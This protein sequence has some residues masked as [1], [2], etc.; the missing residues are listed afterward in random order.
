MSVSVCSICSNRSSN[1][2]I[3]AQEMMFG[4]RESYEYLECAECRCLQLQ[5]VPDHPSRYYPP[6]YYSL[7]DDSLAKGDSA[8]IPIRRACATAL[9]RAPIK[10]VDAL[11][12]SK[13]IPPLFMWLAGMGLTTSSAICD[14]GSGN[15]RTLAW[16]HRQGFSNLTGI[17]P[18]I[19]RDRDIESGIRVRRLGVDEMPGDWDLIMLNHSFEHMAQPAK[20]LERL[21]GLLNGTGWV[22]IRVPVADSWACRA[23]GAD[24]VQLDAPRHLFI[25]TERS[26]KVL[27]R[28]TGFVI[29]RVFF[30][31]YSLQFWGSEQYRQNIPLRDPRSYAENTE[32]DLFT[33]GQIKAF[34]RQARHLNRMRDGDSAGFVLRPIEAT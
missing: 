19:E 23:Y 3:K 8:T 31:S 25:H 22:V 17:D 29:A 27:A 18:Y 2:V 30:D 33:R 6:N 20:V 13:C 14:L 11:V 4:L 7:D 10:V 16:M 34:D 21:R 12:T 15:G 28:Q 24:W 32:T 1:N 9:L 5:D 26:M